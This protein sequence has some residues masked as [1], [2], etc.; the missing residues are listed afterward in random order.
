MEGAARGAVLGALAH[1]GSMASRRWP[2][3][4]S[5]IE[6]GG[7]GG[8]GGVRGATAGVGRFAFAGGAAASAFLGAAALVLA[9]GGDL[10]GRFA[11]FGGGDGERWRR[12]VEWVIGS[13]L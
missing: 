5:L 6:G 11:G 2:T 4:R 9:G 7:G 13:R 8:G 10:G 3:S 1:F 12:S